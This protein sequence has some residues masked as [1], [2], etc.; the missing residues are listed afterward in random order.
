MH[1]ENVQKWTGFMSI[2]SAQNLNFYLKI[3]L[4]PAFLIEK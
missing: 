4:I 1:M 2:L 3:L